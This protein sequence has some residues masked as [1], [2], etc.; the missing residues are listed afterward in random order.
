[1]ALSNSH[2]PQTKRPDCCV[3]SGEIL[4]RLEA[5]LAL[6]CDWLWETDAQHRLTDIIGKDGRVRCLFQ[7]WIGRPFWQLAE[8]CASTKHGR[9][10]LKDD[11]ELLRPLTGQVCRV[12]GKDGMA[13]FFQINGEPRFDEDGNF[14]GYW[15]VAQDVTERERL[16]RRAMISDQI[17]RSTNAVVIVCDAAGVIDWVNPGFE[18][19]TGYTLPEVRHRKPGDV[20]QCPET[21]RETIRQLGDAVRD[22][23]EIRTTI[24][25]QAKSGRK[26][27]LDLEIKPVRSPDGDLIGFIAV[28]NDITELLESRRRL[29]IVIENMAAGIVLHGSDGNI[30]AANSE[31]CRLLQMT[32]DQMKGREVL[33]PSW[34]LIYADGRSMGGHEMPSSIALSTGEKVENQM[35][36]VRKPNGAVQWLRVNAQISGASATHDREVVA[37]FVDVTEEENQKREREATR[38]LLKEVIE[39]IPDGVAAFDETDRLILFNEAFRQ[40]YLNSDVKLRTGMRFRDII[41][42]G[43]QAGFYADAGETDT[44]KRKWLDWRLHQHRN[45]QEVVVQKLTDGRWFQIRERVSSSGIKVGV[46]S[47]ITALK[48]AEDDL[49]RIAET[50]PLTRA[51]TR[52]IMLRSLAEVLHPEATSVSKAVFGIVDIDD[53]KAINDKYGHG[54]GDVILTETVKR[55]TEVVGLQ[56]GG[57]VARLGGDEFAFL[58]HA[59][60]REGF[61]PEDFT[62]LHGQL[63]QPVWVDGQQVSPRASLGVAHIPADGQTAGEILKNADLALYR[64]KGSGRNTWKTYDPKY[65]RCLERRQILRE[66][67]Q[68]DIKDKRIGVAF[69]PQV[70]T[71]TRKL[72]GFEALARWS[73]GGTAVSPEEFV[74][75]AEEMGAG[76]AL[77]AVVIERACEEYG[78]L[79]KSGVN[80]GHLA[81]NLATSQLSD[82]G[83]SDWI[84]A[85]LARFPEIRGRLEFEITET[86]LLD[87][88]SDEITRNVRWLHAAGIGLSLDDFGTGYGSLKHLW[89]LPISKLKIDKSFIRDIGTDANVDTIVQTMIVLAH[90]LNLEVVAEGVE[91]EAQLEF[92]LDIGCDSVQ[93]YLISKPM[94]LTHYFEYS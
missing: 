53:F 51:A 82:P 1:M 55:L 90:G 57:L 54:G 40:Y 20:L 65:R 94:T 88:K 84:D 28:Q 67:L 46:R 93:G 36:G 68:Q 18:Q 39:T 7:S 16:S 9:S 77:G 19:L 91:T 32:E 70:E 73:H 31:A 43:L 47:E 3:G 15:G 58:A 4:Q 75:I 59:C 85:L 45:P 6:S 81:L 80:P 33:D 24:L 11:F 17:V 74:A 22:G 89:R 2:T 13:L 62:A 38:T 92:L 72:V 34:G 5:L 79:I 66:A 48:Q 26:Y 71:G 52:D 44:E 27:W 35:V 8:S 10:R 83:F 60:G 87:Q 49:R 23:R 76:C 42:K 64:A 12:T 56:C 78:A 29:E 41:E 86:V 14:L 61:L 69:Q 30:V 37:S 25:N 21:D 63:C 50:D